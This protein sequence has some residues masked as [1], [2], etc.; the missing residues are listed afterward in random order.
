MKYTTLFSLAKASFCFAISMMSVATA[1]AQ[2]TCFVALRV[3]DSKTPFEVKA[4]AN[5]RYGGMLATGLNGDLYLYTNKPFVKMVNESGKNMRNKNTGEYRVI[6]FDRGVSTVYDFVR[7]DG[8]VNFQPKNVNNFQNNI[9]LSGELDQCDCWFQLENNSKYRRTF[10]I[11]RM[12]GEFAG[13][14]EIAVTVK[15][16]GQADSVWYFKDSQAVDTLALY[17]GDAI[18]KVSVTRGVNGV[19]RQITADEKPLDA[20]FSFRNSSKVDSVDVVSARSATLS[21]TD[22]ALCLTEPCLLSLEYS[23][24]EGDDAAQVERKQICVVRRELPGEESSN[25]WIWV[26]LSLLVVGG[27]GFYYYRRY[28]MKKAG[29]IPETDK[30]K[31]VR[32]TKEVATQKE[33]IGGL[34]ETKEQL[35]SDKDNLEQEV[36]QLNNALDN[37]KKETHEKTVE[38]E[39]FRNTLLQLQEKDEK[40]QSQLDAA[41]HRI[42]VFESKSEHQEYLAIQRQMEELKEEMEYKERQ[43]EERL[44]N[45]IA[46]LNADHAAEMEKLNN[47]HN[48]AVEQLNA[49]HNEAVEQ[50]NAEHNEALANTIKQYEEQVADTVAESAAAVAAANAEKEEAVTSAINEKTMAVAKAQQ[51]AADA[52]AAAN[53]EKEQ[54]VFEIRQQSSEQLA[55]LNAEKVEAV[56]AAN[57]EKEAAVAAANAA[58][59]EAV[60]L[61]NEE[62]CKAVAAAIKEKEEA[63]AAAIQEKEEAVAAANATM[64]QAIAAA[65]QEKEEA[66]AT[67]NQNAADAVAAAKQDAAEQ[68]ADMRQQAETAVA[69]AQLK[70]ENDVAEVKQDAAEKVAELKQKADEEIASVRSQAN[71]EV[72]LERDIAQRARTIINSSTSDYILR[73][74]CTVDALIA[75]LE[76]LHSQVSESRFENNH[77]NVVSHMW[78]KASAFKQWFEKEVVEAQA[79]NEWSVSDV[80]KEMQAQL[81]PNLTN[82]YSWVSELARFTAYCS[83]SS[84]ARDEFERS[85]IPD[86]FLKAAYA[87]TTTLYGRLGV[88]LLMPN[89]FVDKFNSEIHK[90]N[91][92]PLINSYFPHGFIEYKPESRGIVYDALHPGY[93]L[94][95]VVQQLP[96]VCTF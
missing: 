81:L 16:E 7:K 60:Y 96:E 2:D 15:H 89:L 76:A 43:N 58:K 80:R 1:M 38:C 78:M 82:N 20:L 59:E 11:R 28:Q 70:A 56:A 62:K 73:T 54:T 10:H 18:G 22:S 72:A 53:L 42:E 39:G 25:A 13:L 92:A 61:A 71:A 46:Q 48:E 24:M 94:E 5:G 4:D 87:E 31:V 49:Q 26:L 51:D 65:N 74:K 55:A 69:E 91:Q 66:V 6:V 21:T 29:L 32:L 86:T 68:I 44:Q 67:A 84:A 52:I 75:H 12:K 85:G 57:A 50:L 14:S 88:T 93:A 3:D 17:P 45:T 33:V 30:E 47:V 40:L 41:K 9:Y 27:V 23:Y 77:T 90:L 34:R 35:L 63:V 19:L 37:S 36:A 79:Q 64:E 95:G 8:T 83:I